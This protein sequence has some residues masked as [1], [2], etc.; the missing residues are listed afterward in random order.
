[1]T[2]L[3]RLTQHC[4]YLR[5]FGLIS[6]IKGSTTVFDFKFQGYNYL[7]LNA[8][9]TEI[10]RIAILNTIQSLYLNK[11]SVLR[12]RLS[13]I[14]N[15]R[16]HRIFMWSNTLAPTV[17]FGEPIRYSTKTIYSSTLNLT[18]INEDNDYLVKVEVPLESLKY[19]DINNTEKDKVVL[20]LKEE[21]GVERKRTLCFTSFQAPNI[22][23]TN[24]TEEYVKEAILNVNEEFRK[25]IKSH[26]IEASSTKRALNKSEA[27]TINR[28]ENLIE[29]LEKL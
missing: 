19:I 14:A 5:D 23:Y 4:L 18:E 16:N 24:A 10:K 1:M 13:D 28:I 3:D 20:S 12:L 27:A 9:P 22:F 2:L 11:P 29:R 7:F 26:V 6:E 17:Q 21:V 8:K 15:I 25:L